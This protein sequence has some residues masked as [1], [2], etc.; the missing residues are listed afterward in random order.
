VHFS[1]RSDGAPNVAV[2]LDRSTW[3]HR[4]AR[5]RLRTGTWYHLALACDGRPGGGVRFYVDGR[6]AGAQSLSAGRLLDLE[7]FRIGAY[8]GW[9]HDPERNFHGEIADVR[10]YSGLLTDADAARI[11]AEPAAACPDRP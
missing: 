7:A 9:Q 6:P 10:V 4:N 2:N 5:P 8:N 11:A 3:F 1:L